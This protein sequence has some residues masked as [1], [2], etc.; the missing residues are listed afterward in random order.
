MIPGM[1]SP[2]QLVPGP[3]LEA[4]DACDLVAVNPAGQWRVYTGGSEPHGTARYSVLKLVFTATPRL[5]I[6]LLED[7]KLAADA[8]AEELVELGGVG[9]T[10]HQVNEAVPVAELRDLAGLYRRVLEETLR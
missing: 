4:D 9:S 1:P 8:L 6:A 7:D 10:M 3:E 5:K 2:A